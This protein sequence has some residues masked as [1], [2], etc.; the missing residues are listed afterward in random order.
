MRK[1]V[2]FTLVCSLLLAVGWTVASAQD[3]P[4]A[5]PS[6]QRIGLQLVD[7]KSVY[8]I[9]DEVNSYENTLGLCQPDGDYR[10]TAGLLNEGN[11]H[12]TL[13]RQAEG[14]AEG[15]PVAR[16]N[17]EAEFNEPQEIYIGGLNF[18]SAPTSQTYITQDMLPSGWGTT[19]NGLLWQ[20]NGSAYVAAQGGLT[21]TVPE[22][23]SNVMLQLIVY[24]GSNARGGYFGYNVNGTGW[25]VSSAVSANSAYT[26]RTFTG[27]NSGD[28]ISIYGGEGNDNDG[29]YLAQSPDIEL[30]IFN[31]LPETLMPAVRVTPMVSNMSGNS[32]NAETPIGT[33]ATYTVNEL[34]SFDG[35]VMTDQFAASTA[36]NEH[37]EH[38]SYKVEYDANL[39]LPSDGS[40]GLD[41]QASADFTATTSSSPTTALFTGPQNWTFVGTNAYSP[42]AGRC[43]YI[44]YYGTMMYRM[45]DTFMGNSVNVTV[46]ASTGGDGAGDLYVNGVQHTFAAGETYTWTVPTGPN[47]AI[48]FKS[49]G[50]TYSN[51]FT[52]IVITSGNGALLNAPNQQ[53]LKPLLHEFMGRSF[54]LASPMSNSKQQCE[55][56]Q[57]RIND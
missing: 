33:T 6:A 29:Y 35:M 34:V 38:Y 41:F 3:N 12:I 10:F 27:L 9:A 37:P 24:V 40:T 47:G 5:N 28:V 11:N 22:G 16:I 45:P 52:R 44:M 17:L 20:T 46:T 14:D 53:R 36:T 32:W 8:N 2:P 31:Y 21:F 13:Y 48:V 39:V 42:S 54:E 18:A 4:A 49:N 25:Y 15:S 50:D 23:Y 57:V 51:D 26:L 55:T 56:Q 7:N 43:A 19:S 1:T 30:I